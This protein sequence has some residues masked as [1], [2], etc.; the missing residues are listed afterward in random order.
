MITITIKIIT[1][2]MENNLQFHNA[3][4]LVKVFPKLE[5]NKNFV[6]YFV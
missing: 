6:K 3:M 2:L 4:S 5:P 1:N